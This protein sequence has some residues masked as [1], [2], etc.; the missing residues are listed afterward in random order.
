MAATRGARRLVLVDQT[1]GEVVE[2]KDRVPHAFDGKGYTLEGHGAEAPNFALSLSGT[3]WDVLDWMKQHGGCANPVRLEPA[4]VAPELCS[5]PNTIK[6]SVA[7]LTKLNLLLRIGGPRSGT[8]QLNPRRFWEG[9][10]EAHVRACARLDPPAV[11]PDPK[12]LTNALK[13]AQKATT[14]A[15]EAAEAAEEAEFTAPGSKLAA[16]TRATADT[17][18]ASAILAVRTAD[19]LGAQL[20]LQLRRFLQEVTQ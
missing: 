11:S 13:A 2:K 1:T 19:S 9:S 14:T 5:T 18:L 10:G 7:R 20:P 12:S 6:S 4:E 16:R 8:Y 3:E 15:R 17:A